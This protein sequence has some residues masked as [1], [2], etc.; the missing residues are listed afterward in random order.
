[1]A[2]LLGERKPKRRTETTI[3]QEILGAINALPNVVGARN[4]V[5]MI[6]DKRGIPVFFGLGEGSPDIVGIITLGEHPACVAVAFGLEV[7]QPGK[8]ATRKQRAWHAVAKRRGLRTGV[9]RSDRE[10]VDA[11]R[12]FERDVVATLTASYEG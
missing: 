7:K 3:V 9:V 8:Y 10:A 5:G 1:M 12:A 6:E 2:I 4:N 11:V